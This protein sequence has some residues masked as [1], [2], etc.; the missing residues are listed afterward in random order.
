MS[1]FAVTA[2]REA[3]IGIVLHRVANERDE[4]HAHHDAQLEYDD[5]RMDEAVKAYAVALG[6]TDAAGQGR[7]D[8]LISW[9]ADDMLEAAMRL[10]SNASDWKGDPPS[11]SSDSVQWCAAARKWLDAYADQLRKHNAANRGAIT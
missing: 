10:I 7:R 11:D 9:P 2:A 1:E 5:E 8:D 3:L 6:T 4:P